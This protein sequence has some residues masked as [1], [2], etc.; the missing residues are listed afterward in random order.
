MLCR[1]LLQGFGTPVH[2]TTAAGARP[3]WCP[4]SYLKPPRV[5]G[6]TR[7]DSNTTFNKCSVSSLVFVARR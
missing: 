1:L 4:R 5:Q 3:P 6:E 2:A 7:P